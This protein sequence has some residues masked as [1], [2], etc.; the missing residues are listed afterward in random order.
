MKHTSFTAFQPVK[1]VDT[2]SMSRV[3]HQDKPE[4]T[5]WVKT[6]MS[7]R[8]STRRR[9]KQYALDHDQRLQQVVDD[10]LTAYLQ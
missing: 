2:T 9:L 1:R 10:A 7:L 8:V 6:S 3:F 4:Q 5:G